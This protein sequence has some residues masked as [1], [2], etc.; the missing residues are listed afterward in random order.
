M[1][2]VKINFVPDRVKY[3][4]FNNIKNSVF[5]NNG[6]IFGGYVRD[7]I[8]SDHNKVI[9]NGCNTYDIHNFWNRRHHPETAARILTAN[10]MDICMY[11]EEDVSNFI[12]ALQNIFNENAGYSNVSSSDITITKDTTDTG[13]FN[14]P[15]IM[16]KKLN[17]KITIGKIPYVYSG[18]ELSFDFDIIVPTIS[19]TQ[20]PFCKVDLL[21]NVFILSNHG[22]VI[23]NHTGTIIDKMSILNKQKISNLIMKDI[24]EFKTQ[25]CL[26]NHS[27][28]FTSGNFS[29]ND[30]V[31]VR[32]NKMLFRNFKWDITNLPFVMCNYKRNSSTRNDIC[33]VCLENFKN[34][35][36]I[37]KMYID[38]S[39]KTEKVCSAMSITHD[40]C[41]F[42][43]LQSQL[44][45]EKQEGISNTDH[46]EFRCP[47]R[48]AINFKICSNNI[49]KIIS[50]KM[51]A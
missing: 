31:L 34:S 42:K 45:T 46:F 41:L 16:H 47:L 39:A 27:D 24:V 2:M 32:I 7:M 15:I 21:S 43:Y 6:I 17:Y 28:N 30:E 19:N 11:C 35:D 29:Y 12:N 37:A 18:I 40:K 13:Y 9:Y 20:P 10:D 33:C 44:D 49:D 26:R 23:S 25:F 50:E 48:N 14:T 5:A 51:N 1:D 22:I 3:I 36:R 4:I 38:N 8:I